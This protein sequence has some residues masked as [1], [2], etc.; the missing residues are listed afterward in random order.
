MRHSI[1]LAVRQAAFNDSLA[2]FI[3]RRRQMCEQVL[4]CRK[5]TCI[6]C[7]IQTLTWPMFTDCALVE[8]I[9]DPYLS[10]LRGETRLGH[11]EIG[12]LNVFHF[13]LRFGR[14]ATWI[15]GDTTIESKNMR[16]SSL[17]WCSWFCFLFMLFPSSEKLFSDLALDAGMA[18][19]ERATWE[20]IGN[21]F[22]WVLHQN[23]ILHWNKRVHSSSLHLW[24][25]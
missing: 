10:H 17:D 1:S 3:H 8:P 21:F 7:E 5:V 2:K 4:Y 6:T 12:K 9:P 18:N 13:A 11:E 15:A 14:V 24:Q 22:C 19:T 23:Q 16:P 25:M 20:R